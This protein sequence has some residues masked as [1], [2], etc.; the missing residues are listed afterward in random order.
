MGSPKDFLAKQIRTTQVM[1]SGSFPEGPFPQLMIYR[2]AEAPDYDGNLPPHINAGLTA[3]A[4]VGSTSNLAI[5]SDVWFYVDHAAGPN[6]PIGA[7]G[8]S[9]VVRE[10][11]SVVLF[12]GDVVVSGTLWSE[13]H[14]MEVTTT[15]VNQDLYEGDMILSGN[16]FAREQRQSYNAPGSHQWF[17]LQNEDGESIFVVS[18]ATAAGRPGMVGIGTESPSEIL[19]VVGTDENG[20][21]IRFDQYNS[22][23]DGPNLWF[24]KFRGTTAAKVV[25][26]TGDAIG[27]INFRGADASTGAPRYAATILA[28]VDGTPVGEAVPG[29][30]TFKTRDIEGEAVRERMVIRQDGTVGVGTFDPQGGN[31]TTSPMGTVHIVWSG[32]SG[33]SIADASGATAFA[34]DAL[35]TADMTGA[36]PLVIW[37]LQEDESYTAKNMVI[38]N[39]GVV[40]WGFP[41]IGYPC[42]GQA[43]DESIIDGTYEDGLFVEWDETTLLGCAMDR[44]NEVLGQLAPQPAP[45]ANCLDGATWETL[46]QGAMA[47]LSTDNIVGNQTNWD[48]GNHIVYGTDATS[49]LSNIAEFSCG[50][51][52]MLPDL[53][54][55]D[56]FMPGSAVYLDEEDTRFGRYPTIEESDRRLGVFY[57]KTGNSV[58]AGQ[59]AM[60]RLE[61][62]FDDGPDGNLPY[63]NYPQG[64]FG[65]ADQGVLRVFLNG[66]DS[67]NPFV[68]IDLSTPFVGGSAAGVTAMCG[69]ANASALIV[70]KT[71]PAHFDSGDELCTYWHRTGH[72][73]I[74]SEDMDQGWN[75][76]KIIH[77]PSQAAGVNVPSGTTGPDW[78]HTNWITWIV[79]DNEAEPTVTNV[80][81]PQASS[82]SGTRHLSGVTYSTAATADYRSDID[83]AY[84]NVY[85]TAADAIRWTQPNSEPDH[86]I[87]D[88]DTLPAPPAGDNADHQLANLDQTRTFILPDNPEHWVLGTGATAS[89]DVRHVFDTDN[90]PHIGPNAG[91]GPGGW[92]NCRDA[93]VAHAPGYLLYNPTIPGYELNTNNQKRIEM[94]LNETHR[95]KDPG[96]TATQFAN[97]SE[98]APASWD[99]AEPIGSGGNAGYDTGLMCY[100]DRLM[101]AR[102]TQQI[103]SEA[104]GTRSA[105]ID[106]DFASVSNQAGG[107]VDYSASGSGEAA[108]TN[109]AA[110]GNY[111]MF[112]RKFE[113][114]SGADRGNFTIK[115]KSK[116]GAVNLVPTTN[117]CTNPADWAVNAGTDRAHIF[118]RIPDGDGASTFS[119]GGAWNDLAKAPTGI[120]QTDGS[121][122]HN[123]SIGADTTT[124]VDDDP[125]EAGQVYGVSMDIGSSG[126]FVKA[127]EHIVMW[128]VT[129]AEFDGEFHELEL[130]WV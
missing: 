26:D 83:N 110:Y 88:I 79:D 6:F 90:S 44:V 36:G 97:Q 85:S 13:R 63:Y 31:Y 123:S 103:T 30:L 102:S 51:T 66:V 76:L 121:G 56:I 46:P 59:T 91:W 82:Y 129:A 127:G 43:C 120:P 3:G 16:F 41:T 23:P 24:S 1:A 72:I 86:F 4:A 40:K 39:E 69:V 96:N 111:R 74:S 126:Y 60:L 22:D 20:T 48:I 117:T 112:F 78:I 80:T 108:I 89:V 61:I 7:T 28:N 18:S 73:Q 37:G 105:V 52:G 8:E 32:P 104:W 81:F 62:N 116:N 19:H 14:V 124:V 130:T 68:E 128:I 64:G 49:T 54:T 98:L 55:G 29:K 113:N 10:D 11:N 34:D 67:N 45:L 27:A 75:F 84:L 77:M 70:S 101:Q 21:E 47:K 115:I 92:N 53:T 2:A 118:F 95:L 58:P 87:D 12:A 57:A 5:G 38:D 114:D 109:G 107:N 65:K 35:N 42:T 17:D 15:L 100:N 93:G 99:S 9:D 106:G 94:F 25:V 119:S 33:H 71:E 125:N 50:H 122:C